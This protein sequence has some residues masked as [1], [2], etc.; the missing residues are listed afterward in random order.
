MSWPVRRHFE[1]V[2]LRPVLC[3]PI[4]ETTGTVLQLSGVLDAGAQRTSPADGDALA[5][6]DQRVKQVAG[7]STD[8]PALLIVIAHGRNHRNGFKA[9]GF[10]ELFFKL[11]TTHQW[12]ADLDDNGTIG[13]ELPLI[14]LTR[15]RAIPRRSEISRESVPQ[16]SN[17]RRCGR[18]VV[19]R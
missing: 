16:R 2:H 8:H 7:R 5:I 12:Q 19:R 6:R 4:S 13:P 17:T 18:V 14:L 3:P 15:A 11:H 10:L 1:G 9:E